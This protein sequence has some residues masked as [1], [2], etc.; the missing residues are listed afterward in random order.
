MKR[1]RAKEVYTLAD[2]RN[3]QE[4]ARDVDS[5]IRL[6]IFGDPVE[7][8]LSPKMQNAALGERKLEMQY[9]PF[10]IL[11]NELNAALQLVR[12]LDFVGLNLTVPHKIAAAADVDE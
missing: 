12:D 10:H 5:P 2:L 4:G 11:P 8:S 3:W 6:G 7:H 1:K 9:A